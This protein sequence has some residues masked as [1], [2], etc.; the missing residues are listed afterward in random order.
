M[1]SDQTNL[2]LFATMMLAIILT[3]GS[4]R[5]SADDLLPPPWRGAVD[6]TFQQWTFPNGNVDDVPPDAGFSN[7]FGTPELEVIGQATWAN[8][9]WTLAPGGIPG[10]LQ[11]FV[12]NSPHLDLIKEVWLQVTFSGVA[13][14][15]IGVSGAEGQGPF[16]LGGSQSQPGTNP[17]TI[18]FRTSW[19]LNSCPAAEFITLRPPLGGGTVVVHQA[20]IDTRCIPE[21]SAAL[22][23]TMLT[24]PALTARRRGMRLL[25]SALEPVRRSP[26]RP[27]REGIS[28]NA[29]IACRILA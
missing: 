2:G 16:T 8:G 25:N 10:R 27:G 4:Q 26:L 9:A 22:L 28:W 5:A 13:P 15:D 18:V 7:P 14:P 21:P 12:H 6:T 3:A 24:L 23:L 20:V 19:T 11:F 17:D 1:R 29:R